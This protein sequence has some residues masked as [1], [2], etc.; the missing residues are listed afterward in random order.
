M[1]MIKAIEE[2]LNKKSKKL[3]PNETGD[4]KETLADITLLKK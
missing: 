4:V 3:P 1:E 2:K